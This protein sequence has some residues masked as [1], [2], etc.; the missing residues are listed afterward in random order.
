LAHGGSGEPVKS[1][2]GEIVALSAIA[3]MVAAGGKL[4][5]A[6]LGTHRAIAAAVIALLIVGA[7]V[8]LRR[9]YRLPGDQTRIVITKY[10]AYLVAAVLALWD[11]LAPAKWL[12]GSCIAAAEV[13]LVFDIIT[14]WAG[15]NVA[16][17]T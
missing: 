17:G 1:R 12:P 7:S 16:G 14:I 6:H 9:V 11:V 13:A 3:I 2:L 8:A 10:V 4:V 5:L 15:R